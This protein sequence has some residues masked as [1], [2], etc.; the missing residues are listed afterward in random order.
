[1]K[2][3]VQRSIHITF[4]LAVFAVSGTPVQAQSSLNFANAA[5]GVNAPITNASGQRISAPGPFA[6]ELFFST[7]TNAVPNPLGSDSLTAAGLTQPFSSI[8]DGYFLGGEKIV[9]NASGSILGQ[10]RVW[11]TSYGSTYADARDNGG[12]FGYSDAFVMTL[13]AAPE[14]PAIMKGM[15]GFS[16]TNLGESL[17]VA[18]SGPYGQDQWPM[19]SGGYGAFGLSAPNYGCG[20][21][22]ESSSPT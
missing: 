9:T 3:T 19:D 18:G 6:A 17:A 16:L 10:V 13:T 8:F 14:T 20:L 22:L 4:I 7:N 12:Q 1:M 5:P 2:G 21:W 15:E 11:D